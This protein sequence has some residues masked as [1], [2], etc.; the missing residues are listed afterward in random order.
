MFGCHCIVTTHCVLVYFVLQTVHV[1]P[2]ESLYMTLLD[3]YMRYLLPL[4]GSAPPPV[5]VNQGVKSAIYY[6]GSP[7]QSRQYRYDFGASCFSTSNGF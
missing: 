2:N 3:D 1:N 7:A 5:H 6:G 4:D